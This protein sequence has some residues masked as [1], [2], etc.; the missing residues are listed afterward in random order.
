LLSLAGIK[1]PEPIEGEDLSPFILNKKLDEDRTA[2]FMNVSPFDSPARKAFRGIRTSRYTYVRKS[3]G[4]WLLYDNQVDPYQMKNL[5]GMA[6]HA[7]LQNKLEDKLQSK[8]KQTG[9]EFH[10]KE[11]YLEEWGYTVGRNGAVP[12]FIG[13]KP[14]NFKVQSPINKPKKY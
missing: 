9:D 1:I 12:Y 7:G 8:L 14:D 6:E 2:L 4:P 3:A 11:H 10:S 13:K 5:V